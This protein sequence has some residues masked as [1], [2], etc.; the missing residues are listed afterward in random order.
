MLS[1]KS[2]N[3]LVAVV[4]AK[5]PIQ[6]V[7]A[8]RA[9]DCTTRVIET[10]HAALADLSAQ[11]PDVIVIEHDAVMD[12]FA[13]TRSLRAVPVLAHTPIL[14]VAAG[15]G[16][17]ERRAALQAGA[18]DVMLKP[19]DTLDLQ[20]RLRTLIELAAARR[21]RDRQ[22][23]VMN[24]QVERAVAEVSAREREIVRRLMLAAEFR[25]DQA[26]DHLTRVA[27]C[28]IA[29][30]EG[31]GLSETEANDIALASTMHDIGKIGIPDGILLKPGPLTDAEREE[32][33]Q[34]ALRGYRM[35]HDSPSRLLQ[36]ASEIALTH[37]ERWDGKGYPQGLKGDEIPLPGR[38]VAV[39]DVF[40]ALISARVYKPAWT[41]EKARE[42][43]EEQAGTHFDPA[44][45]AAFV[46]RWEDVVAL[47]RDRPA[48]FQAN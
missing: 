32:M 15:E 25:D 14:I 6:L 26:G 20:I 30:A 13:L 44:C 22:A 48:T 23:L 8:L 35:L 45:V 5:T 33:K 38:I 7:L 28:T 10:A 31:L 34:H 2:G 39:A 19:I 21:D 42:H 29:V 46:S 36:L 16:R 12:S 43:L 24:E 11:P 3:A 40:D 4:A 47:I 27:G 17:T 9:F 41:P 18:T 1:A 37:H